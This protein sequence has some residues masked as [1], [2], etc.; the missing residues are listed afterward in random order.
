MSSQAYYNHHGSFVGAGA[1]VAIA[2]VPFR[3][4][5]IRFFTSSP[6]NRWGY[7][8]DEMAGNAYISDQGADTGVTINNDGFTV[9][10]GADVNSSGNVVHYICEA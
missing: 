3:P 8:S 7:K 2:T 9:A 10:N 4:K 5:R 6:A 1:D